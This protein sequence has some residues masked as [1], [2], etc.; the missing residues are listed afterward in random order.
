MKRTTRNI[1]KARTGN[2]SL[3]KIV[4]QNP[5]IHFR[6]LLRVSGVANATLQ[7][8]LA[9]L[10]NLGK[11]SSHRSGSFTRYYSTNVSKADRYL[12]QY[13]KRRPYR[14]III[15]LLDSANDTIFTFKKIVHR[16][17]KSPSTVSAQLMKL[18][19]DNVVS[20]NEKL[21]YTLNDRRA[22]KKVMLKYR[23]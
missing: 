3:I 5:G 6:G 2:D 11:L 9:S 17:G 15:L 18:I 16:L 10:E 22:I 23:T 19:K 20:Y 21:G 1:A 7:R 12:L 13:L 14:E 4:R 8:R